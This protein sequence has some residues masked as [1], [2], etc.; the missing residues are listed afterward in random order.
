MQELDLDY[1]LWNKGKDP[2]FRSFERH[3]TKDTYY[4]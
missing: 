1:Y 3:H 2:E 4:Y